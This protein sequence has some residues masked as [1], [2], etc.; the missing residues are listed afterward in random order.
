MDFGLRVCDDFEK[1]FI[2]EKILKQFIVLYIIQKM[3]LLH[4][5]DC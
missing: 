1:E 5:L 3:H 4:L 2:K